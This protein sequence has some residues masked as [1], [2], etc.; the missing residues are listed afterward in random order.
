MGYED[1]LAAF[2]LEMPG[3]IPRTEYGATENWPLIKAVTGL[4]VNYS[5]DLLDKLNAGKAFM[6]AWD[7]GLV[8]NVLVHYQYLQGRVTNMGHAEFDADGLDLD[9]NVSCPFN[10]PEE[11]LAYDPWEEAGLYEKNALTEQFEGVYNFFC[12]HNPNALNMS[13]I[14]ITLFSGMIAVFGWEMLLL[15]GGQDRKGFGKVVQRYEKWIKQFFEAFAESNIPIMMVHDDITWTSGPVFH[16]EF[17]REFIFP[18]YTRLFAPIIESGK[19]IIFTSDGDY[20]LFFDDLVDCGI[21]C[22]VMEPFADMA[23]FAERYGKTHSF[24][25]N[26]DTRILLNGSREQ[27]RAEVERCINIGKDCP[28]FFMAVGNQI[29][30]NTPVDNALYYNEVFQELR[31]R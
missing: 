16:P 24:I 9:Q 6:D 30:A 7:Y 15:A 11:V 2:N 23:L 17:Y 5:S 20:T 14:Y 28:G 21:H 4:K 3:K 19:K 31:C 18:A 29:P 25:G 27:I 12:G 26:A 8:W 22:F 13:G 10:S 1:A